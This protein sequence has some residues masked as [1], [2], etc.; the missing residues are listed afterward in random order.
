MNNKISDSESSYEIDW[1]GE[2]EDLL[3]VKID[4]KIKADWEKIYNIIKN[5]GAQSLLYFNSSGLVNLALSINNDLV[6][7]KRLKVTPSADNNKAIINALY[8][9]NIKIIELILQ[10]NRFYPDKSLI[11]M[12][13]TFPEKKEYISSVMRLLSDPRIV[14]SMSVQI[15]SSILDNINKLRQ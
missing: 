15:L 2:I 8:N 9:K 7:H 4:N 14:S 10:D 13:Y 1:K 5:N 6:K 3:K 11:D 12:L